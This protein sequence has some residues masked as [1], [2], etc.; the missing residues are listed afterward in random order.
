[1]KLKSNAA[2]L[3]SSLGGGA[4]G[5][6]GL[7]LSDT[8][9]HT[10]TGHHFVPIGYPGAVATIPA[11]QPSAALIGATVRQHAATL[12]AHYETLRADQAI[13]QQILNAFDEM[14]TRGLRNTHTGYANITAL[15]LITHMYTT[16]GKIT[17][18]DLEAND[19]KMK[20]PYDSTQPIEVLFQQIE[21]AQ[22]FAEAGEAAYSQAT[23]LNTAYILLFKTGQYK[24]ACREW[25]R[26]PT[27]NK[28]WANLKIDFT[29]ANAELRE[30]QNLQQSTQG[31][32]APGEQMNFM[33]DAFQHETQAA[34]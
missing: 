14:Y 27:A 12:R 16:Y 17:S 1:M 28:T 31:Y 22:E 3:P 10:F 18:M 29:E 2:S 8:I 11:G 19:N 15:Q 30:F 24:D 7:I 6:L 33:M 26:K 25:N 5:H 13:K 23:L 20:A 9:Y 4:H 21:E 34:I 32:Q